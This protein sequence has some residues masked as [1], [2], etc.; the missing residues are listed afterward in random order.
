MEIVP[1]RNQLLLRTPPNY[2]H[3]N[4]QAQSVAPHTHN[5]DR[6]FPIS[7][8]QSLLHSFSTHLI[9]LIFYKHPEWWHSLIMS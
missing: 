7:L 2:L 6:G 9:V 5:L 8:L 4:L 1:Q 3:I